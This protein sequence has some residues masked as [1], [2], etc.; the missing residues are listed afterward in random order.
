MQNSLTPRIAYESTINAHVAA[1]CVHRHNAAQYTL[2]L[3][4]LTSRQ[5]DVLKHKN[6]HANNCQ[7]TGEL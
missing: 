6:S 5:C 7:M 3:P 2:T 1:L 4:I